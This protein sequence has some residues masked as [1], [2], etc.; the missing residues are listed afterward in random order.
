M[1]CSCPRLTPMQ[2][3]LRCT[4]M[5]TS[6]SRRLPGAVG[7]HRA[8]REQRLRERIDQLRDERDAAL[9]ELADKRRELKRRLD[10]QYNL[11]RQVAAWKERAKA[12]EWGL[13][14]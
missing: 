6:P 10:R 5:T 2:T 12:A 8:D 14:H 3:H 1:Q 4:P 13:K 11:E 7:L 9:A